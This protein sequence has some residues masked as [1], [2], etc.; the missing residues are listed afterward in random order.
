MQAGVAPEAEQETH[1][2]QE[3]S[4]SSGVGNEADLAAE[5]TDDRLEYTVH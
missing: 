2:V 4:R 1:K 3:P 5:G